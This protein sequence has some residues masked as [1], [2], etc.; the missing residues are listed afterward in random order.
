MFLKLLQD[1]DTLT[2]DAKLVVC[3]R[4]M[5]LMKTCEVEAKLRTFVA[6]TNKRSKSSPKPFTKHAQKT[7]SEL[8]DMVAMWALE[9][10]IVIIRNIPVLNAEG[11][12]RIFPDNVVQKI[13][14]QGGNQIT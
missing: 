9:Q 7:A 3:M 10:D 4:A 8:L 14:D 5:G 11:K 6:D 1:F 13:E 12:Q 2:K